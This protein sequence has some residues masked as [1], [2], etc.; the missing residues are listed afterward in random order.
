MAIRVQQIPLINVFLRICYL[1]PYERNCQGN[2]AIYNLPIT[3]IQVSIR[4]YV[5]SYDT[6][7]KKL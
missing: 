3:S 4:I 2:T 6:V 1:R 5:K 7:V